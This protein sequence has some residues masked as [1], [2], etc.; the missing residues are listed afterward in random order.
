M[1]CGAAPDETTGNIGPTAGTGPATTYGS[2]WSYTCETGYTAGSTS[3]DITC[4]A[5][6]NWSLLALTC[7]R[8]LHK[9]ICLEQGTLSVYNINNNR[10]NNN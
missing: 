4:D 2:I 10:N 8:K 5:D 1:D 6:G 9:D 3:G 7:A